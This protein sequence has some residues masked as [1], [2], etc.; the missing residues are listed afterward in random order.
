MAANAFRSMHGICTRPQIGSQVHAQMVFQAHLGGIFN[1]RGDSL[2]RVGRTLRTHRAGR[3]RPPPAA[4]L[5]TG[6]GGVPFDYIP[7]DPAVAKA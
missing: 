7:D 4:D 5:G 1:L 3:R 6:D 2:R